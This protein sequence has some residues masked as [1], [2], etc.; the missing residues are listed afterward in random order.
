MVNDLV[1]GNQ[2]RRTLKGRQEEA[3]RN[4]LPIRSNYTLGHSFH[5]T[6]QPH[7]IKALYSAE[8][9]TSPSLLSGFYISKRKVRILLIQIK[10]FT[11]RLEPSV[12]RRHETSSADPHKIPG[13]CGCIQKTQ[14]STGF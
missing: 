4:T 11:R 10:S 12:L 13:S 14:A 7:P 3:K 5:K 6:E 8:K 1:L 2:Q 9:T